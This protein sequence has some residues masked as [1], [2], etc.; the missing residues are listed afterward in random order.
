MAK[1]VRDE[2]KPF[3]IDLPN[4]NHFHTCDYLDGKPV[5]V[6]PEGTTPAEA[7]KFFTD[8]ACGGSFS[9]KPKG[10]SHVVDQ[11]VVVDFEVV[12]PSA[13]KLN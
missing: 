9:I 6:F 2:S 11:L 8:P 1:L 7:E 5:I 3:S 4:G 10:S 13:K 12:K